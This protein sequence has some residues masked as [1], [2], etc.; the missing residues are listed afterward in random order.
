MIEIVPIMARV[1]LR[2]ASPADADL[3]LSWVNSPESLAGKLKT[4]APIAAEEH[5]A[6]FGTRLA[7]P[8]CRLW[9]AEADGKPVGQAR[10]E[11]RGGRSEIDIF[12]AP[13]FRRRGVAAAVLRLALRS[14]AA[15][16]PGTVAVARIRHDNPGSQAL[17]RALGF[18]LAERHDD[19]SVFTATIGSRTT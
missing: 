15:E 12:I 16:R 7:D 3:L 4:R 14:L 18:R 13:E 6:W 11:W 10:L 17:F 8:D 9:I 1:A 5:G 19:H 2:A